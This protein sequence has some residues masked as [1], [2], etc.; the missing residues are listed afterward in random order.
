LLTFLQTGCWMLGALLVFLNPGGASLLAQP[1]AS[2]LPPS[3]VV[4]SRTEKL[5]PPITCVPLAEGLLW[6]RPVWMTPIPGHEGQWVVLEHRSGKAWRLDLADQASPHKSLFGDF[7]AA[8]S[9]GPWEG[10]MC[11]AFHPEFSTNRRYFLKHETLRQEQRWTVLREHRA[12]ED[13]LRDSGQAPRELCAMAQP[14]DNHNGGTLAFGPD[15]MLYFAMGDGGPQEDPEGHSQNLSSWLGK[16]HRLD[17]DHAQ[18]GMAYGIPPDNPHAGSQDPHLRREIFAVG[19]REPWRFSFDRLTGDCWVG[20]VGQGKY[21]EVA[22]VGRGENH[23]WNVYEGFEPFSE[24]YRQPDHRYTWPVFVYDR[25][26]GNSITGGYVYRGDVHSDYY[27]AYICGDYTTRR[28]WAVWSEEGRLQKVLQIAVAPS[29]V[30]SF[31][32]AIDGSLH[33]VGYDGKLYRLALP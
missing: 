29:P 31:A 7:S 32:E 5:D 11:L 20:D 27:G 3:P 8:V 21:E 14:A 33:L 30:A 18:P 23:G 16:M 2:A 28:V 9:D 13:G 17:V 15:G 25:R 22:V 4:F 6:D 24:Q 1:Q 26:L 10:L 12:S 19:L